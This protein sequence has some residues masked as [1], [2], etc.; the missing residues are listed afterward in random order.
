MT[1]RQTTHYVEYADTGTGNVRV[2]NQY[3]Q[4]LYVPIPPPPPAKGLSVRQGQIPW[5]INPFARLSSYAQGAVGDRTFTADYLGLSDSVSLTIIRELN[6]SDSLGVTDSHHLGVT[7]RETLTDTLSFTEVNGRE[8]PLSIA[9]TI[10]F[11]EEL[12]AAG[13]KSII[14]GYGPH[15]V[16]L[17]TSASAGQPVFM[18]SDGSVTLAQADAISTSDVVGIIESV[19]SPIGYLRADGYITLADWTIATG[20]ASLTPGDLYYLN[21]S[22]P[23]MMSTTPPIVSGEV[24]IVVG[25]A[26]STKTLAIEISEGVLL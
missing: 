23:G 14:S 2:A 5:K 15:I 11:D 18:H 9:E 24:V 13:G 25:R 17:N 26:L 10:T 20:G 6:V 12:S 8:I 19:T 16:T 21:E 22:S 4:L 1:I 3:V 7:I